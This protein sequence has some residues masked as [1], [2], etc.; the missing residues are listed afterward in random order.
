MANFNNHYHH[1]EPE[2]SL[3]TWAVTNIMDI[4]LLEILAIQ[5]YSVT[6]SVCEMENYIENIALR[7][8]YKKKFFRKRE[9]FLYMNV[10]NKGESALSVM[11]VS[12][13]A[14]RKSGCTVRQ[15]RNCAPE[16]SV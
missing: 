16:L 11:F 10:I 7:N 3:I 4:F 6:Y 9:D 15:N 5:D 14:W 13:R 12:F 2:K 8:F 1:S